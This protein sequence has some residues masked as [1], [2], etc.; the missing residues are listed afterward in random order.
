MKVVVI[1]GSGLIGSKL[2]TQLFQR[3]HEVLA[4]S[5]RSGVNTITGMGLV[6]ALEGADVV[7]D[8]V[9]SP[10]FEGTA[11]QRFFERSSL[12]LRAAEA[13]NAVRYHVALSVV[14]AERL[15]A[16]YY[17]CAK[18]TQE[19]LI[20]ESGIPYTI[21]RCTQVFEFMGRIAHS[22]EYG[23]AVRVSPALV[24]PIVWFANSDA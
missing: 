24:Q 15:P 10:S 4:A 14:G 22:N 23:Q 17:C 5:R 2:V 11:V 13:T 12:N 16:C 21:L 20:R 3:G 19:E 7:V 8:V 9:N 1:G 18:M 6:G